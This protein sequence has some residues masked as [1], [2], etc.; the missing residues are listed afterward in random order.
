MNSEVPNSINGDGNPSDKSRS[1]YAEALEVL[2]G[3]VSRNMVRRQPH[4]DYAES[5]TGC[6]V[7]DVDGRTRIDF[8]NNTASLIHGHANPVVNAA[9]IE[10]LQGGTGFSMATEAELRFAQHLCAR[11][12]GFEKIRF[13]NSG[14]EAVMAAIKA[15][16][17]I[18]GRPKIAK[19]E[20]TYHGTYDYAE[21]SQNSCPENWGDKALPESVA[22]AV[23]TPQRILDDVVVFPFNDVDRTIEILEAEA[24]EL[25]CVLIDPLPHRLGLVSASEDYIRE[26][27]RWTH[28]RNVLLIFDEVI[29]F[30]MGYGGAQDWYPE[31]KPDFTA[32][33]KII[34]G[35]FPAGALAG[36]SEWMAV[37]DPGSA[38]FGLP[39]SGTFSANPVTMAAGL[40]AMKLYDQ[41]AVH[42]LNRLGV[43]ARA[44]LTALIH[45][46]D[47]KACVTG[48]GS[49]FRVYFKESPPVDYRSA[50]QNESESKMVRFMVDYLYRNGFMLIGTCTAALS[51]AH[52]EKEVE[53][54]IACFAAGFDSLR[55]RL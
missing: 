24:D 22:L 10:Q 28:D 55:S 32:L 7:T 33:G 45:K 21:V 17:A 44:A 16:R 36:K 2:A 19:A 3:G 9:V 43:F 52:T 29:S 18:T 48:V 4:P 12:N 11:N 40:A 39:F 26:L 14:T 23:G 31:V 30:R 54:L 6:H 34:G 47:I 5:G 53:Q 46:S 8:G 1:L 50:W 20:G 42:Q 25:A 27:R 13:M 37:L 49:M 41:D 51:T 38:K 15:S 35:G